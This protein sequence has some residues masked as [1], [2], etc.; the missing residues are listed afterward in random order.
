M[1]MANRIADTKRKAKQIKS[2]HPD[3]SHNARLDIAAQANGAKHFT[4]L[5]KL[6]QRLGSD[7]VPS[8]IAIVLAG[9]SASDSL[10]RTIDK[11]CSLS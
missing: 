5:H 8:R 4:Q 2:D 7:G 10:M 6:Q 1:N 11:D 3:T 9:G